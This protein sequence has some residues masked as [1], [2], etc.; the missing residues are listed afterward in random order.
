MLLSKRTRKPPIAKT[1]LVKLRTEA[2]SRC[3]LRCLTK[4]ISIS[5]PNMKA[6]SKADT[7]DNQPTIEPYA[8][9]KASEG[10]VIP[11]LVKSIGVDSTHAKAAPLEMRP[12]RIRRLMALCI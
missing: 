7:A 5:S 6:T 2:L 11:G 1:A 4:R 10:D 12:A 3:S 8:A 9:R